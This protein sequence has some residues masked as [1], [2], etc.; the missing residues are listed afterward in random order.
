[1]KNRNDQDSSEDENI[2]SNSAPASPAQY[3][4]SKRSLSDTESVAD[5]NN[6]GE[7]DVESPVKDM[8]TKFDSD[9]AEQEGD[10]ENQIEKNK[11]IS[12]PNVLAKATNPQFNITIQKATKAAMPYERLDLEDEDIDQEAMNLACKSFII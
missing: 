5:E 8:N 9:D 10:K 4:S 11:T 2:A 1:M 6:L 7:Q 12:S 3:A